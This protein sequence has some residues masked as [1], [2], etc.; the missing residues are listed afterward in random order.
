MIKFFLEYCLYSK[1]L[2]PN[3]VIKYKKW[4]KKFWLYLEKIWKDQGNPEDI[5]IEDVFW[6]IADMRQAGLTP[7]TCNANIDWVKVYFRYLRDMLDKDVLDYKKIFHCKYHNKDVGFYDDNEKN[8][9]KNLIDSGVWKKGITQLK[10]KLLTYILLQ[11]WLRCH[12]LAKIRVD[13]IWENLRVLGKWWKIR[14]VYLR[15]ELL[16]MI[17]EY[18]SK[19]KRESEWLFPATTNGHIRE[20]SIRTIFC[21]MTRTLWFHIHAHKFRHTFAT[22]LLHIPWSSIYDVAKL[23]GHSRISTTQI[24]L[25]TNQENLKRLQ[26]WL[27]F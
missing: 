10:N 1:G 21:K 18:L 14:T 23:M 11:T 8:Q 3:T 19:R 20:W 9:I 17:G 27:A 6:F 5:K 4:L 24:Y 2:S 7:W 26:F 16:E 15:P 22:D 12:E 13:E 25:G